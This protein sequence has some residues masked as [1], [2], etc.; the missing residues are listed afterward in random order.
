MIQHLNIS[1]ALI[2]FMGLVSG[3]MLAL[4]LMT[5]R[6]YQFVFSLVLLAA[7]VLAA[8]G[9]QASVYLVG[10]LTQALANAVV[11]VILSFALGY[12]LTAVSVLSYSN[13]RKRPARPS[14][15]PDFTAVIQLAPG[16]PPGSSSASGSSLIGSACRPAD[17]RSGLR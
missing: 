12:A 14:N 16:E 4:T 15:R 17:M 10:N 11:L 6:R 8:S 5:T 7:A 13:K 1:I 3:G 2:V 9:V